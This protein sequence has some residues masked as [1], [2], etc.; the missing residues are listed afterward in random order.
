MLRRIATRHMTLPVDPSSPPAYRRR[1]LARGR[2]RLARP[3]PWPTRRRSVGSQGAT[4]RS[5]RARQVEPAPPPALPGARAE[6]TAV[7]PADARPPPTCRPPRRCS[8]RSTAATSPTAKD[9]VSRGA[10]LNGTNVLGLTPLEL[11]V[12]L[13]RNQHLV[14]AALAARRRPATAPRRGAPARR[15]G[16]EAA[17]AGPSALAAARA[18][19]RPSAAAQAAAPWPTPSPRRAAAPPACSP[20]TAARRCRRPG[21]WGSTLPASVAAAAGPSAARR[22]RCPQRQ[23]TPPRAGTVADYWRLAGGFWR[24]PT[25]RARLAA[26][27][28]ARSR[29]VIANIGVQYGVNR[30]NAFFFDAL[31]QEAARRRAERDRLVRR[32]GR[33]RLGHQRCSSWSPA[34]GCR[35]SGGNG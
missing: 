5:S 9:A 2:S 34:C 12:D 27:D 23:A 15:R 22:R 24:G 14:P 1:H 35:C 17:D 31:E 8:T 21:S 13:G 4:A 29:L 28:R 16:A 26:D 33:R 11:S 7:A 3:A 18:A 32:A 10:D 25:A 19:E 20:A 30:W 6:P